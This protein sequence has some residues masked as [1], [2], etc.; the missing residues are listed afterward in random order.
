MLDLTVECMTMVVRVCVCVCVCVSAQCERVPLTSN[1]CLFLRTKWKEI[2]PK[3]GH[4]SARIFKDKSS[5]SHTQ[6]HTHSYHFI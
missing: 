1:V 2:G 3:S 4:S 5:L 6:T